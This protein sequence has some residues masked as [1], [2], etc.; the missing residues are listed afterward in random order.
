MEVTMAELGWS[1]QHT[2]AQALL[3]QVW[4][5]VGTPGFSGAAKSRRRELLDGRFGTDGW[6]FAHV[7]R[8]QVVP[9]A[10]A[11]LEYEAAY[12][13]FLRDRPAIVEL[14]ATTCGNVYDWGVENVRDDSYDQPHTEMNHYQD[15]SVRRVVA[16]FVDDPGWP[17]VTDTPAEDA[18]LVDLDTGVVHRVPR[19]R[20]MRGDHLLQIRDPRSAGYLLSPAVVPVHDPALITTL[21]GRRDWYHDEGCAH[22][23]V[24]A[25]W[26]MSKVLEVRY[27][28]FLA[29]G[30]DRD[31]PLDEV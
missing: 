30:D 21:P 13:H 8:G 5:P 27:D 23:S 15:I 10:A 26:Q 4:I 11:I 20:G 17:T 12:R 24:E 31:H 25:F 22:L 2:E 19:A 18:D 16:E 3:A 9:A 7:V 29:L 28:R 14:L 6:R 1:R